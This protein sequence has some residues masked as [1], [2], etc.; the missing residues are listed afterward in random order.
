MHGQAVSGRVCAEVAEALGVPELLDEAVPSP[1][2]GGIDVE[3][4]LASERRS[5]RLR[6]GDS[7]PV[8]CTLASRQPRRRRWPPSRP[9]SRSP[10]NASWTSS[11]RCRNGSPAR[12]RVKLR[13]H[14]RSG[15]AVR[16][17]LRGRRERQPRDRGRGLRT[18][19][20]G[21][22]AGR[23]R[24]GPRGLAQA[25]GLDEYADGVGRGDEELPTAVRSDD[26]P[27]L[28]HDQGLEVLP[29][30]HKLVFWPGVSVIVGPNG[31]G[32][33]NVTDAVLWALGEQARSRPRP[34]DAG[35]D[36]R[37]RRGVGPS[38]FAEV[39]VVLDADGLRRPPTF[40]NRDH[41]PARAR[42]RGR[43]PDQR[44]PRGFA[45]VIEILAD[46]I[47]AARCTR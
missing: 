7:A 27:E 16:S 23:G 22:R 10:P 1:L 21:G 9:R 29:R 14:R 18:L 45:D 4:L 5:P 2:D 40:A 30:P 44:R 33:S 8:T 39:E 32:K 35:H 42:G 28:D 46:A 34:V 41:A 12:P 19:E 15:P 47:S 13:G 17:A 43:L 24:G 25:I 3:A 36:L 38:R 20:E 31:C 26:A 37:R 11:R 6:G